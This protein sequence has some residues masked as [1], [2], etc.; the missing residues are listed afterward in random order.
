MSV[1]RQNIFY[2]SQRV[3]V[4]HLRSIESSVAS[5]FD[6]LAGK[7]LTG[8]R[9][10]IVSGFT[11]PGTV[12][13]TAANTI[14]MSVSGG[15]LLHSTATESGV[16]YQVDSTITSE[17]LANTNSNI[18]GDWT[19]GVI[20]Y[21]ALDLVR[22]NDSSTADLVK[23][24]DVTTGLET[25]KTVPLAKTLNYKIVISTAPFSFTATLCPIAKVTLSAAG[26]VTAIED[27]RNLWGRLGQGGDTPNAKA[28]FNWPE[29]RTESSSDPF[30]GGDKGIRSLK[31]WM[32]AAMHRIWEVGG[33]SA[34][35]RPNA[36]RN[37]RL[38]WLSPAFS[39]GENFEW[40]G[41]HLHW[42]SLR[43]LF[44]NST[45]TFNNI[46]DQATNLTGTTDL[47]DGDCVYVDL[48]RESSATALAAQKVP[49]STLGSSAVP[50][51]RWVIAW[52]VG[53]LIYTRDWRYAVGVTI[54]PATP[55]SVGGVKLAYAAGT[56]SAPIVPPLDANN[57]LAI[58]TVGGG[59]TVTGNNTAIFGTGN[60]SG[61]GASLFGGS[62]GGHGLV[63]QGG[64]S[65]GIGAITTGGS[66]GLGAQV[67]GGNGAQGLN[68]TG[69]TGGQDG[70]NSFGSNATAP[71]PAGSGI[72]G[73]GGVGVVVGGQGGIGVVGQGGGAGG[74]GTMGGAGG[75]FEGGTGGSN[76]ADGL[77][78]A[79]GSG[80]TGAA[81]RAFGN[82]VVDNGVSAEFQYSAARTFTTYV[83]LAGM[84]SYS[85]NTGALFNPSQTSPSWKNAGTGLSEIC[86]GPIHI[87]QGATITSIAANLEQTTGSSKNIT[88]QL[89]NIT[90][91][92]TGTANTILGTTVSVP[93]ATRNWYSL[94]VSATTFTTG[95]L[96]AYV[97]FPSGASA[98][99]YILWGFK[100]TY[101]MQ[102]IKP[103]I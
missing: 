7:I 23:F 95:W 31:D 53:S 34:W 1:K 78:A 52:R 57:R 103:L 18:Q 12:V 16:V 47:A 93:T 3:D 54:T 72:Y 68:A 24:K 35:Y 46:A 45:V 88:V 48:N 82:I 71:G 22:S 14:Q 75:Y 21:V 6:T 66:G 61:T 59:I 49:L 94:S 64:A 96:Q 4:P 91:S 55:T 50:G 8:N 81:V 62:S 13:N 85:D 27:A 80:G 67:L 10:L 40:D 20:N 51:N 87:P 76:N 92:G 86:G 77:V 43:I 83:S 90:E 74:L 11:I 79:K 9:A 29:G 100:I 73:R 41:T 65:G 39:G 33:G 102:T 17:L 97:S 5:D 99:Q 2:G 32:N 101:T 58:G 70:I 37:V 63:S 15:S 38:V 60:G 44:D 30:Y 89:V 25:S 42:K 36:D 98:N 26:I 84:L 28:A 56:P 19:Y 69:G